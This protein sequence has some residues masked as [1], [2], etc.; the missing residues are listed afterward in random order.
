MILGISLHLG[1]TSQT[2]I[3]MFDL[4]LYFMVHQLCKFALTSLPRRRDIV[5]GGILV[6]DFLLKENIQEKHNMVVQYGVPATF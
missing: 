4:N 1:M 3:S 2:A 5:F 6:Q